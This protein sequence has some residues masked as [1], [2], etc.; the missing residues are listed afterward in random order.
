[1]T[2]EGLNTAQLAATVSN[3]NV[4]QILGFFF[5]II[6]LISSWSR[7]RQGRCF[8]SPPEFLVDKDFDQS[9]MSLVT[10]WSSTKPPYCHN[11]YSKS[12]QGD[13]KPFS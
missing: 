12:R 13:A 5:I 3:S 11:F 9:H 7:M 2:F 1:M 10:Q 8:Y 6:I 4:L